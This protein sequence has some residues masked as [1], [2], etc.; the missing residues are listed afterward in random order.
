MSD[1]KFD[2]YILLKLKIEINFLPG[3]IIAKINV[4]R[5]LCQAKWNISLKK[6][7]V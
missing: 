1:L 5:D 3:V 6:F 2:L 7:E 4:L